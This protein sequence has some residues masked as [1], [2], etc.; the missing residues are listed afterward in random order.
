MDNS[1]GV[2]LRRRQ[3]VVNVV[4]ELDSFPKMPSDYRHYTGIGGLSKQIN[5]IIIVISLY[6]VKMI[7]FHIT[8]LRQWPFSR[9]CSCWYWLAAKLH[10]L[11]TVVSTTSSSPTFISMTNS[12]SQSTWLWPCSVQVSSCSIKIRKQIGKIMLPFA[13][14]F[15]LAPRS[16]PSDF[17]SRSD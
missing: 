13:M 7:Q 9:V 5:K 15:H 8:T 6:S 3:K 12:N 1:T 11:K 4:R 17:N 2:R 10:T 14:E 16:V